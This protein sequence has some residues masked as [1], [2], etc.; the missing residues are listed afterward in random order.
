A[1][2]RSVRYKVLAVILA[3]TL[4]ALLVSAVALLSYEAR[5]YREFLVADA[6][7][8]ADILARTTAPA[9]Q[10][11]D[12]ETAAE[13]LTLLANRR[14]ILAAAIYTATGEVFARWLRDP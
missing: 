14:G 10:F 5:N 2:T 7:T 3:T 6:T 4:I 8:Q 13:N 1:I 9:L 12:P 11:D